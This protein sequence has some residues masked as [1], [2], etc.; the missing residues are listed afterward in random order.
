MTYTI[1]SEC[2]GCDRCI[3]VCPSQAIQKI[4]SS[5]LQID[6]DRCNNCVPTH[7]VPQCWAAC[8]TNAGCTPLS[9]LI[10]L[11][12]ELDYWER[13]FATY[14]RAVSHL[15]QTHPT[16]YWGRWFGRYAKRLSRLVRGK[17]SVRAVI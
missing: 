6:G 3:T 16:D 9:S 1:T 14:D 7:S 12:K 2:I 15:H 11:P 4:G 8:P 5:R 13:W 10:P 17:A